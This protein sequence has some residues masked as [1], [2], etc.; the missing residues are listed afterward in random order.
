MS[1][2]F[3]NRKK[4]FEWKSFADERKFFLK[5]F[6]RFLSLKVQTTN[7]DSATFLCWTRFSVHSTSAFKTPAVPHATCTFMSDKERK[8]L[9]LKFFLTPAFHFRSRFFCFY[10]KI[11]SFPIFPP[12]L[13]SCSQLLFFLRVCW[14]FHW[15]NLLRNMKTVFPFLPWDVNQEII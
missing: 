11:S 10:L 2:T 5:I 13:F 9:K 3:T 7:C 15:K 1:P 8:K 4:L 12:L 6:P 14:S